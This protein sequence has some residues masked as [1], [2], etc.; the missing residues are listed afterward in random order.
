M[1]DRDVRGLVTASPVEEINYVKEER[2]I[3]GITN[4]LT[5]SKDGANFYLMCVIAHDLSHDIT[6]QRMEKK[7]QASSDNLKA[8]LDAKAAP[9]D[10]NEHRDITHTDNK[11]LKIAPQYDSIINVD[12][13]ISIIEFQI[14]P[15]PAPVPA[16]SINTHH[17]YWR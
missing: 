8:Q 15:A 13:A 7:I 10:T 14:A 16:R 3:E 6:A 11:D 5:L 2:N 9:D 17:R 4:Y 1:T 12:K